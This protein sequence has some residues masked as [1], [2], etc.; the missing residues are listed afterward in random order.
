MRVLTIVVSS[1]LILLLL[2]QE[3]KCCGV[4][5]HTEINN[6][7]MAFYNNS[8]FG[9]GVIKRILQE[10]QPAFQVGYNT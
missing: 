9:P 4:G 3:S 7:A 5:T 1:L 8:I 2:G 10:Q 6:R